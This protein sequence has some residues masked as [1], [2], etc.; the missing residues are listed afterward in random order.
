MTD[1]IPSV[2]VDIADAPL[3]DDCTATTADTSSDS[4][5]TKGIADITVKLLEDYGRKAGVT[6]GKSQ[7]A[8]IDS[9]AEAYTLLLDMR[10]PPQRIAIPAD[11]GLGK[12]TS[13]VALAKFITEQGLDVSVGIC[14]EQVDALIDLKQEMIANGVPAKEIGLF[15]SKADAADQGNTRT[16]VQAR[17][18]ALVCHNRIYSNAA[19]SSLEDFYYTFEG[20]KRTLF[21]WDESL[22]RSEAT[23]IP[24]IQARTSLFSFNEALSEKLK[25]NGWHD[26][27]YDKLLAHTEA[28]LQLLAED[29]YQMDIVLDWS[30]TIPDG[31]HPSELHTAFLSLTDD[32]FGYGLEHKKEVGRLLDVSLLSSAAVVPVYVSGHYLLKYRTIVPDSLDRV[33]ILDASASIRLVVKGDN[34]ISHIGKKE[35]DYSDVIVNY[36]K[37][38]SGRSSVE[39]NIRGNTSTILDEVRHIITQIPQ[40]EDV[41]IFT[42]KQRDLDIAGRLKEVAMSV[43]GHKVDVLTWGKHTNINTFVDVKYIIIVGIMR[44]SR[45][46]LSAL[47]VG[48]GCDSIPNQKLEDSELA[49]LMYQAS[50]RGHGRRTYNDKA[51]RMNIWVFD[52]RISDIITVLESDGVNMTRVGYEPVYMSG[53]IELKVETWLMGALSR[54]EVGLNHVTTQALGNLLPRPDGILRRTFQRHLSEIPVA[55]DDLDRVWCRFKRGWKLY[56]STALE[57]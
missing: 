44:R 9:V 10:N 29:N 57:E 36:W 20:K 47:A 38:P 11:T 30:N 40:G 32:G 26:T 41:L 5:H 7:K 12:T 55:A 17:R 18:I 46:D 3:E 23:S 27:P 13:I 22:I 25:A 52:S 28:C 37:H 39:R 34:T 21:I 33:V 14:Q 19:T 15:H 6:V 2:K 4:E 49:H 51:G 16:E 45:Q 31:I 43:G 35:K 54:V 8:F 56:G 48:Q 24:L 53:A 42:Y 50:M 1:H